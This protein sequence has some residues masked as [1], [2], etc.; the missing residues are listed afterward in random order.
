MMK[1][2][3]VLVEDHVACRQLLAAK[4]GG[5]PGYEII[6]EAGDGIDALRL[7]ATLQP[8]LVILDLGLPHLHGVEVLK[9]LRKNHPQQRIIIFSGSADREKIARVLALRP[10]G[11]V[12]KTSCLTVL[13][14]AIRSVAAGRKY[15][16]PFISDCLYDGH[17]QPPAQPITLRER[18][19]LQMVAEGAR[20]KEIASCLKIA[21][22]TVDN[23]RARLMQKLD[24][25]DIASLTRYAIRAG[26]VSSE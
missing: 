25:H 4:L 13:I 16:T 20:S 15:L 18:E 22:K 3:L 11:Y 21:L 12:E 26:L 24:C 6:G 19:V 9:E 1:Q 7:C 23:H 5:E 17:N 10:H 14:E 2:R 8:D